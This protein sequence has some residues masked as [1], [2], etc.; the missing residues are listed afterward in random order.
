MHVEV[1]DFNF[2]VPF[3]LPS[4]LE[5][6]YCNLGD[7]EMEAMCLSSYHGKQFQILHSQVL[8]QYQNNW[9]LLQVHC[10]SKRGLQSRRSPLPLLI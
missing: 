10:R 6:L 4:C 7:L 1:F 9:W 3:S 5:S 8:F 2:I